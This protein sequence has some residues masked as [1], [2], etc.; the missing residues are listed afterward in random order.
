MPSVGEHGE[1]YRQ[2]RTVM[3]LIPGQFAHVRMGPAVVANRPPSGVCGA[4]PGRAQP[5]GTKTLRRYM[6]S[7]VRVVVDAAVVVP[8]EEKCAL[9]PCKRIPN[10]RLPDIGAVCVERVR[11]QGVNSK[12]GCA[13]H[14]T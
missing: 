12:N 6:H 9:A 4:D 7:L 5:S 14:Q 3:D 11:T 2:S 13:H 1:D 8:I 10:V